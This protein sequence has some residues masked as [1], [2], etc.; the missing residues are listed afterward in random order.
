[1]GEQ[2]AIAGCAPKLSGAVFSSCGRYRYSLL[3]QWAQGPRVLWVMLNPSTADGTNDDPTIRKVRGFSERWGFGS[4][5]VV[6][7]FAWRTTDPMDLARAG[8]E[9]KDIVG[10]ENDD[11]ILAALPRA[12]LV[13]AAWGAHEKGER[14]R[15]VTALLTQ[16][17]DLMLVRRT[18]RGA[19]EHPLYL[20]YSL[21][22][23]LYARW[24]GPC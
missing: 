3:R 12:S 22:P 23:T 17:T 2:L 4:L 15:V 8:R 10:P 19:P 6:N 16:H 11:A 7:L 18:R 21:T 14:A 5:E 20:P 9:G 13:V 24:R 1:V